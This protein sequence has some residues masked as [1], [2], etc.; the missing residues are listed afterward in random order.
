LPSPIVLLC[1]TSILIS[2]Y[3]LNQVFDRESD[4]RNDKC[5]YLSRGIF[6]VRTLVILAA[7]FFLI[8]SLAFQQIGG[9]QRLPLLLAL[10]L[11]LLY[12]LPPV[13]LCAR[14]F[15]DL[16]ANAVG[17]GGVAY[18]IG[19]GVYRSSTIDAVIGASPYVFL[20]ASTFLHTTILDVPG[21][22]ATGKISTAVFIGEN[23]SAY[24]AGVLHAF[25]VIAAV[26]S[27]NLLAL[28]ITAAAAPFTV[29]ALAKRNPAA[30]ALLIQATTLVVTLG[31]V[32][33]WPLYAVI[34]TPLVILARV[35][36]RRRFG[37]IY[38]GPQK[39]A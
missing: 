9:T 36:Y 17:Y 10:V 13:R 22:R 24:L 14:P 6:Q 1:L 3:L 12:S 30:S 18:I 31:A 34:L 11:S 7:V 15:C 21:D 26:A 8:A 27:A 33:F 4:E 38:P 37:I 25:G 19:F 20:V 32:L 2:A 28:I 35:Y 16:I 39:S 23:R 29:Y 5:F